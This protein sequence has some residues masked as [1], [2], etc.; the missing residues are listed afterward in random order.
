M[1]VTVPSVMEQDPVDLDMQ[2][3][4]GDLFKA[5]ATR[6]EHDVRR[7]GDQLEGVDVIALV[8]GGKGSQ[9][10]MTSSGPWQDRP[11]RRPCQT[12]RGERRVQGIVVAAAEHP[13]RAVLLPVVPFER[14]VEGGGECC[15]HAK[16]ALRRAREGH[17]RRECPNH[18]KG[19]P[20][21]SR[22]IAPSSLEVETAGTAI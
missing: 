5:S 16:A 21:S 19:T 22:L 2:R 20:G 7:G 8:A 12:T 18:A 17:S 10:A 6:A 1:R 3:N 14:D 11:S 13:C 4:A 9:R 15:N